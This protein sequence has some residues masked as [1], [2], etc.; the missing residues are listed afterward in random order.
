MNWEEFVEEI[1]STMKS[2]RWHDCSCINSRWLD[3]SMKVNV[4][5]Y[6]NKYNSIDEN[7]ITDRQPKMRSTLASLAMIVSRTHT[8]PR[9]VIERIK[10]IKMDDLLHPFMMNQATPHL[11]ASSDLINNESRDHSW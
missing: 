4:D 5:I 9:T 3:N 7:S 10:K 6:G 1:E 8:N 11:G 2:F